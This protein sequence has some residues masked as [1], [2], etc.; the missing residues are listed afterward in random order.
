MR[1]TILLVFCILITAVVLR[2]Q[3][4]DS[5]R[6][7]QSGDVIKVHYKILN[8]NP[9]Q[10][11]RVSVLCSINGG[12]KSQLNSISGDV[13]ENITGGHSG[14]MILWDVLKDVDELNS[15]E[16]FI[17]AELVKDLSE[18][19]ADNSLSSPVK[20]KFLL[21]AGI[22]TP[23]PKG[24]VR[25][26]YM[27]SYGVTVGLTYGK[28]PV[29]KKYVGN[30]YYS[31]F[32]PAAGIGI[33]ITKRI[34]N[35]DNFQLHLLG[36]FRNTDLVVYALELTPPQFWNH[37]MVGLETGL[38]F[39]LKKLAVCITVSHFFPEQ[40]VNQHD[41]KVILASPVNLIDI[42]LGIKF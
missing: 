28:I 2:S 38:V 30:P 31:G 1:R 33:D 17:K 5:I 23:G 6:M 3:T 7:E 15:A 11:F 29:M 35:N 9:D 19:E 32:D 13:G 40:A 18:T 14:Y 41:E 42:N 10:V 27:G 25:V 4:V 20:G 39:T 26:G 16:F 8:S 12:L 24:A 22:E 36:G 37:G 21:F 34:V